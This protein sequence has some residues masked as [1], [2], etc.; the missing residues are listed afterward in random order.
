MR[1]SDTLLQIEKIKIIRDILPV[2]RYSELRD[3]YHRCNAYHSK[4][5]KDII[6]YAIQQNFEKPFT[7]ES[8][9]RLFADQYEDI[10]GIE[11]DGEWMNICVDYYDSED[12]NFTKLEIHD[13]NLNIHINT[14]YIKTHLNMYAKSIQTELFYL[15][16]CSCN[17]IHVDNN[18]IYTKGLINDINIREIDFYFIKKMILLLSPSERLTRRERVREQINSLS[19]ER[20]DII[21]YGEHGLKRICG[22]INYAIDNCYYNMFHFFLFHF[23]DQDPEQLRY[24]YYL[25]YYLTKLNIINLG[26]DK[27]YIEKVTALDYKHSRYDFEKARE[28]YNYFDEYFNEYLY[29]YYKI[30][31]EILDANKED[32]TK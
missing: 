17:H 32:I 1:L 22:L 16:Y 27:Q 25:G 12:N 18:S 21:C 10:T 3:F 4:I 24:V 31:Q 15:E 14:H 5:A 29:D 9:Y 20:I 8:S 26:I 7:F 13:T 30:I 28:V 11:N 19:N 23:M 6:D 2:Y